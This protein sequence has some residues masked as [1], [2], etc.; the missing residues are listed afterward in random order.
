VTYQAKPTPHASFSRLGSYNPL[1]AQES[2]SGFIRGGDWATER[3]VLLHGES[4]GPGFIV[5][6]L[7]LILSVGLVLS[8]DLV[9]SIVEVV[10]SA[11]IRQE[12]RRALVRLWI[13]AR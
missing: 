4:S 6:Q 3:H 9:L 13:A 12:G 8:I 1:G 2:A 10:D 5:L 7:V 11:H